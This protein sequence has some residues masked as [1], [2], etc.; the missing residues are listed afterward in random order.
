MGAPQYL[1]LSRHGIYYFRVVVPKYLR[2]AH[3][4]LPRELRA[5]LKRS[6]RGQAATLARR[7]YVTWL[8]VRTSLEATM[9]LPPTSGWTLIERPYERIVTTSPHDTPESLRVLL[10]YLAHVGSPVPAGGVLP[11]ST[12]TVPTPATNSLPT[13]A[14]NL[15]PTPA[16]IDRVVE[17]IDR[18]RQAN[19]VGRSSE[20]WLRDIIE[21]WHQDQV[22]RCI[23][24]V[25]ETWANT[26]GPAMRVFRELI[27]I[28]QRVAAEGGDAFWDIRIGML[29][30]DAI[31]RYITAIRRYPSTQ[32]KRRSNLDAKAILG[33]NDLANEKARAKDGDKADIDQQSMFNAKNA[34]RSSASL[35]V[36]AT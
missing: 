12:F 9:K 23:W 25:K 19:P 24:K 22:A 5:S 6:N 4:T 21:N 26:Y 8:V 33:A 2:L 32:G 30:I 35:N 28:E 14:T 7:L 11:G 16:H 13:P 31:D 36:S 15:L 10:E 20:A 3:P 34:L 17:G 18:A 1:F 27:A 29:D